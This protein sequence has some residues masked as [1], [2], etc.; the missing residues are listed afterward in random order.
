MY[1]YYNTLQWCRNRCGQRGHMPPQYLADELTL[2][3]PG[4]SWLN[5][6]ITT[7]TSNVFHLPA[8]LYRLTPA[9]ITYRLNQ[10]LASLRDLNQFIAR[11]F[12]Q[13]QRSGIRRLQWSFQLRHFETWM[14]YSNINKTFV[15]LSKYF[16][17]FSVLKRITNK[18]VELEGDTKNL[19]E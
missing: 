9:S 6:P 19:N 16:S 13:N 15:F 1:H 8:S 11:L 2:F 18:F 17:V 14:K 12:C 7:G 3:Q 10:S 5:P 4:K